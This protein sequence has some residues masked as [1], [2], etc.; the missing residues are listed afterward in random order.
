[1]PPLSGARSRGLVGDLQNGPSSRASHV[2]RPRARLLH[3]CLSARHIGSGGAVSS[4]LGYHEAALRADDADGINGKLAG[5]AASE[6]RLRR[7]VDAT[8]GE[9]RV[10][11]DLWKG[12]FDTVRAAPADELVALIR[13]WAREHTASG[14]HSDWIA[15]LVRVTSKAALVRGLQAQSTSSGLGLTYAVAIRLVDDLTSARWESGVQ[16]ATDL[17]LNIG[18]F[19]IWATFATED[20]TYAGLSGSAQDIACELG[21][22]DAAGAG[23]AYEGDLPLLLI[24]YEPPTDTEVRFPTAIEAW[25]ADPP[26]YYFTPAPAGARWGMTQPWPN[27]K[28]HHRPRP[29]VVHRPVAVETVTDRVREVY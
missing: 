24:E 22:D 16:R 8:Q 21:F 18:I 5:L 12:F 14:L 9:K 28:P 23:V 19:V 6:T 29:E 7:L 20:M 4:Y 26:N 10:H 15:P 11:E 17:G 1:M 3:V 27:A 13:Q 25:A 2:T